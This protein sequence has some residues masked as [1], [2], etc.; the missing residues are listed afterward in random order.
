MEN[1]KQKAHVLSVPYPAQGHI[2]PI[3]QFSKHL[4]SKGLKATL[5]TTLFIANSNIKP[6]SLLPST[7]VQLDTISDGYD[8][9][10]FEQAESIVAYLASMETVGSKTLDELILR[11]KNSPHPIDCIIYDPFLPWALDV[12]KKH[13]LVG[14]A[15]FTQNCSVNYLYYCIYHQ[16]LKIPKIKCSIPVSNPPGLEWID[17]LQDMPSYVTDESSYPA[18]FEMI[19]N[20]FSNVHKADFFLVNSVLELEQMVRTYLPTSFFF[21]HF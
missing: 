5:A 3:L 8:E 21:C 14:V 7:K 11:H 6:N 2:N 15:F 1:K 4:A 19:M 12:A 20:Q 17:Q 10:G 9:G 16:I 18:Y 13:G